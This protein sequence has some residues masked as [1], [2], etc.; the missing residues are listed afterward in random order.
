[1]CDKMVTIIVSEWSGET[2][3]L[4]WKG[5]DSGGCVLMRRRL[6]GTQA[7]KL[8]QPLRQ[9]AWT[10]TFDLMAKGKK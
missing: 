2:R 10:S 5:E 1:M 3:S 8:V 4:L 7:W 6:V 9:Q